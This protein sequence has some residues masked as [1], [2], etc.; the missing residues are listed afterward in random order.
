[1]RWTNELMHFPS[2]SGFEEWGERNAALARD[3]A[4][5]RGTLVDY[6]CGGGAVSSR[7]SPEFGGTVLVDVNPS[8]VAAARARCFGRVRTCRPEDA[9]LG[10][11]SADVVVCTAVLQHCD[12]PAAEWA[13]R[14][15]SG[16]LAPDGGA[17][18]QTRW[19][20]RDAPAGSF[21]ARCLW[22]DDEAARAMWDAGLSAV[23]VCRD[24]WAGY[25][26]WACARAETSRR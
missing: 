21:E 13:L 6:G 2:W 11:V 14:R 3:V 22:S 20:A 5:G 23:I 7:L 1:M 16:L 10:A 24:D 4:P 18:I 15:I 12:P 26:W 9:L 19:H 17:L 25:T 8:A